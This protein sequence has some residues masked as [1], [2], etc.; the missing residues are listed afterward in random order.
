MVIVHQQPAV[1]KEAFGPKVWLL[2]LNG[3]D[4]KEVKVVPVDV[5]SVA[6]RPKHRHGCKEP[7]IMQD[8]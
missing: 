8:F 1:A 6:P 5:E 4:C 2:L 3:G 7:C